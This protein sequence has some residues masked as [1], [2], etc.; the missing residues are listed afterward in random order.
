MYTT[1]GVA[2]WY[3]VIEDYAFIEWLLD[4]GAYLGLVQ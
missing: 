2:R 4:D 1:C 3:T